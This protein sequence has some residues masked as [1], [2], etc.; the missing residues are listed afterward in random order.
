MLAQTEKVLKK[1]RRPRIMHLGDEPVTTVAE[2]I[3]FVGNSCNR[4]DVIGEL[5]G[6]G[7]LPRIGDLVLFDRCGAY[8]TYTPT[9][10]LQ[11]KSPRFYL[12]S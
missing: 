9:N 2:P 8:H 12:V 7:P 3:V 11:L 5:P 1:L 10:F 6:G 4:A